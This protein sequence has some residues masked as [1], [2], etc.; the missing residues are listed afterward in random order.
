MI[1]IHIFEDEKQK[2]ILT[3]EIPDAIPLFSAKL[4]ERINGEISLQFSV[5]SNHPDGDKI[6][7]GNWAIIKD[8]D[9][10]YRAFVVVDED[11]KHDETG[12]FRLFYC[13]DLAVHELNDEPVIDVRP[14]TTVTD[15]LTRVLQNTRW[16]VGTVGTFGT[17]STNVYYESAMVGIQKVMEAWGGEVRFRVTLN[18]QNQITGRY[19]DLLNRLGNDTGKRFEYG[20]NLT[21]V[22]RQ[23]DMKPLKT[24]LYGRGKGEETDSGGYGR[25]ITFKDVV[26]TTA[27]GKPVNKPAGQEWVGDPTALASWGH[28]NANGSRRHRYGFYVNE[29]QTDPEKLLQETWDYLQSIKEPLVTYSMSVIGLDLDA[30]LGDGV[31]VID[32]TFSWDV[33]VTTRVMEIEWDY[34]RPEES[35]VVL[36]NVLSDL[37]SLIKDIQTQVEKKVGLGDP[38]GWLQGIIDAARSEFHSVNGFVYITDQD[39]ILITNRPKD[40]IDNPPDKAMQLK[41]GGLGISSSRNPDGTFNFDTFV[42]G[43]QVIADRINSGKIKTNLVD[44]GDNDGR[45]LISGGNV[46]LKGGSLSVYSTMNANEQG[47]MISGNKIQTNFLRNSDFVT[48]PTNDPLIDWELSTSSAVRW[49]SGGYVAIDAVNTSGSWNGVNQWVDVYHPQATFQARYDVP[50]GSAI[51]KRVRVF[52]YCYDANGNRLADQF[53]EENIAIYTNKY[54]FTYRITFTPGTKRARV[55][56]QVNH[57]RNLT[58][59]FKLQYVRGYYDDYVLASSMD[60]VPQDVYNIQAVPESQLITLNAPFSGTL[61]ANTIYTVNNVLFDRPFK[62]SGSQGTDY[63]VVCN[64]SPID[65]PDYHCIASYTTYSGFNLRVMPIKNIT[66]T[67]SRTELQMRGFAYKANY[68]ANVWSASLN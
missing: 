36:G 64:L 25:R 14:S 27:S 3:N 13:E 2:L 26:W 29:E 37:G 10:V 53:R 67:T 4:K 7:K 8:V 51:P 42:L 41:A 40:N 21:S 43:G 45:V 38:I 15:A 50:F 46:T 32:K 62:V 20:R 48:N 55:F 49:N 22:N 12:L 1:K 11:E 23:I 60:G 57:E 28:W 9:G 18:S 30:R 24:A 59:A 65:F 19:V 16:S 54:L 47:A 31:H 35:T 34:L 6:K 39:G 58:N 33:R 68:P 61:T 63:Q 66:S 56:F 17:N 44:V 52:I 5:P